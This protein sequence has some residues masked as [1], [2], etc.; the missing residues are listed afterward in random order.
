MKTRAPTRPSR[1]TTRMIGGHFPPA[2]AIRLRRLAA[3]EDTTVQKLLEEAIE[4]LIAAR[5]VDG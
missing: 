4:L 3:E 5:K 1:S 2:T